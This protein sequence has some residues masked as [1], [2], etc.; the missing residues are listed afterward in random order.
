MARGVPVEPG[1]EDAGFEVLSPALL[2]GSQLWDRGV[3]AAHGIVEPVGESE[4]GPYLH[5]GH[6]QYMLPDE[7][8]VSHDIVA[9]LVGSDLGGGYPPF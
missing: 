3:E 2:A 9:C 4:P 1:A 8:S 5:R 6:I 7:G